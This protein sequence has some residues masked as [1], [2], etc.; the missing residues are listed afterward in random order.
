MIF[1][2]IRVLQLFFLIVLAI[3]ST[4]RTANRYPKRCVLIDCCHETASRTLLSGHR[5]VEKG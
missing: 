2:I 3:E 4:S 5:S 1:A